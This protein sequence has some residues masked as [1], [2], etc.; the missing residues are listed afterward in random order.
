MS[1]DRSERRTYRK[2]PGREY[3]YD[4][5]PLRSHSE[6]SGQGER[7]SDGSGSGSQKGAA[8]SRPGT[9]LT[10]R[11]DP[12]R[13]RQLMRQSIIASKSHSA[14]EDTEPIEPRDVERPSQRIP[15]YEETEEGQLYARPSRARSGRLAQPRLPSTRELMDDED[16]EMVVQD[17]WHDLRDVDP[18]LAFTDEYSAQQGYPVEDPAY[19]PEIEIQPPTLRSRRGKP[20][21]DL[22]RSQRSVRPYDDYD[23]YEEEEGYEYEYEEGAPKP[24]RKKKKGKLSRRGLLFGMGSAAAVGIGVVVAENAPKIPGAVGAGVANVEQQVQDAFNRGLAQGADNAR[25]EMITALESLEGF[26][27]DGAIAAARLTRVAYDVFVS[28]VIKFG[29]ALTGDFLSGMLKAFKTARGWLAQVYQDNATLIAIQKVLESWVNDVSNMPKQ[30]DAITQ[31][32]LDGAQ[33][34]LRALQRKIEEEKAKLN[35]QNVTPT[36]APQAT[37]KATQKST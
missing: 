16:A 8:P 3:G 14:E 20:T 35:G 6:Q 11:P 22:E 34:Y 27:L 2:S 32:D 4:Y 18:D 29:A 36:P 37:P 1:K 24:P 28:P 10:Q 30:L 12:R 7:R 21:R 33:A 26:T 17:E 25:K 9:V 15:A 31:T 23:E 19:P 5:D 13:T